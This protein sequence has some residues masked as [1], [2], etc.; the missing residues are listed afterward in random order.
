MSAVINS[1]TEASVVFHVEIIIA[2]SALDSIFTLF[3]A[4]NTIRDGFKT[5]NARIGEVMVVTEGAY[6]ASDRCI[7]PLLS[8]FKT[9]ADD[10][11]ALDA[12]IVY[13]T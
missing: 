10:L 5:C 9:M 1:T 2:A 3:L 13:K 11:R 7:K 6:P 4:P 12:G 8:A